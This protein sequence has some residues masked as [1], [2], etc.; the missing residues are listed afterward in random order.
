MESDGYSCRKSRRLSGDPP[1][2]LPGDDV[3]PLLVLFNPPTKLPIKARVIGW[4][5]YLSGGG[6]RNMTRAQAVSEVAKEV[7]NKY[8]HDN[9]H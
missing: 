3:F 7:E 5:R 6:K 4:L 8:F 2:H 1:I 9:V